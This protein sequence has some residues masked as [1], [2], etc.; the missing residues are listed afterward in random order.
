MSLRSLLRS[1][2]DLVLGDDSREPP[3][4]PDGLP[5]EVA[6]IAAAAVA[7]LST[8]QNAE[9]AELYLSRLAR[10]SR[11][12]GMPTDLLLEIAGHLAT[13]MSYRDPIYLAQL[14]L[15]QLAGQQAPGDNLEAVRFPLSDVVSLLPE[16]A[17]SGAVVALG[18]IGWSN[19]RMPMRFTA[20]T[21]AGVLKLKA[22]A[23]LR[24]LRP[25]SLRYPK[26][27]ALV[28]RWLHMIDRSLAKRPDAALDVARTAAII[29]GS[30]DVYHRNVARWDVVIDNLVKPTFD[31]TIEIADLRGAVASLVAAATHGMEPDRLR[32]LID[33]IKSSQ[34]RPAVA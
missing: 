14:K 34:P 19:L 23:L 16:A 21:K 27:R 29:Q 4:I 33:E 3:P 2:L 28:E 24:R 17:A 32:Q 18:L 10:F 6:P 13:R 8:Y 31:G 7:G 11:R 26:E 5:P 30:G 25:Q 9:Y 1:G 15:E 20:K 22:I 12:P